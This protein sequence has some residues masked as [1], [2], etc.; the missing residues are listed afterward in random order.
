MITNSSRYFVKCSLLI[1]L[2][3][4]NT[5][6]GYSQF[7]PQVPYPGHH[8]IHKN[9]TRIVAWATLV[10]D[11]IPGWIQITDTSLGRVSSNNIN[12]VLGPVDYQLLSLG[13]GGTVT[14]HI[15]AGINNGPGPDF[16]V[17]ENALE[18]LTND[19]LAFMELAFVAVSSDGI[20]FVQF[21]AASY[22]Q[23]TVQI[24]N[25][26]YE[27]ATKINNLAGKYK[28]N[29]GTPFDLEDIKDSIGVDINNITHIRIIDVIGS[30]NPEIGSLDSRGH[31]IN[32]PFPTPFL[33]CGFDLEAIGVINSNSATTNVT[34]PKLI[35]YTI[36]PNPSSSAITITGIVNGV[37]KL[38]IS[39]YNSHGQLIQAHVPYKEVIPIHH[40]RAGIY[41]III[42]QNNTQYQ[43]PFYKN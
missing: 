12:H 18:H 10:T 37:D 35:P 42:R 11:F 2:F 21:P 6:T 14:C 36:Y 9:D 23:D 19:S 39:I 16:V 3:L 33:S 5:I 15:A 24:D 1:L 22:I 13:D 32:D 27:H 8:A 25:F 43:L 28:T 4:T 7:E 20:H 31:V 41:Q 26:G 38:D 34:S 30:I 17:F 40:L 29:W